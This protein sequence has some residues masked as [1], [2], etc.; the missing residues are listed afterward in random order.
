MSALKLIR[1]LAWAAVAV[2]AAAA[3]FG[4]LGWTPGSVD[5]ARLPL[6][7]N[8]GGPFELTSHDGKRFKS[9]ELAGKPFAVFFGFTNCPDVCPTTMLELTNRMA[10]LGP[11]ADRL[12][13]VFITVDPEQDTPAHLQRY[14]SSF[15]KRLIALTGTASEI[16]AVTKA[17]RAI[18]AKVPIKDGTYTMDHTATVYLMNAKGQFAGTIAYQ[19]SVETQRAKLKKL[20]AGS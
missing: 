14:I 16:A 7:A 1:Y 5:P 15:D 18:Y 8:I 2:M 6:A 4:A 3:G 13:L 17:Y 12:R 19:E 9:S 10:E 20:V 11:D